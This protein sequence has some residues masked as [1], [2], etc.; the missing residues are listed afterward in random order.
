MNT[1]PVMAGSDSFLGFEKP[2]K[3]VYI[4]EAT[5]IADLS[6]RLTAFTQHLLCNL[7]PFAVHVFQWG[8]SKLLPE[9]PEKIIAAHIRLSAQEIDL[10]SFCKM[11]IDEIE[12]LMLP[13]F[14]GMIG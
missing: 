4:T 6:D 8:N 12:D 13:A 1:L 5:F 7:D 14:I 9:P 3:I 11:L 2:H 10:N